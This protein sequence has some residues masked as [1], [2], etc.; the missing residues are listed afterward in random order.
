MLPFVVK[1]VLIKRIVF[2]FPKLINFDMW[3]WYRMTVVVA[4]IYSD[5]GGNDV[6]NSNKLSLRQ[7]HGPVMSNISFVG[8]WFE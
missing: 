8:L 6:H 2:S 1:I 5:G 4:F 3:W 7:S